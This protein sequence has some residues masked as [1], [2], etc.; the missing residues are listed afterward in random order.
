MKK[1]IKILGAATFLILLVTASYFYINENTKDKKELPFGVEKV[2]N[3]KL[4]IY[5]SLQFEDGV[6]ETENLN[7]YCEKSTPKSFFRAELLEL[8]AIDDKIIGILET[9]LGDH[10]SHELIGISEEDGIFTSLRLP[11]KPEQLIIEEES[12]LVKPQ[13]NHYKLVDD[14]FIQTVDEFVKLRSPKGGFKVEIPV[15]W[16]YE[17]V[18]DGYKIFHPKTPNYFAEIKF[19][20]RGSKIEIPSKSPYDYEFQ[21]IK[22]SFIKNTIYSLPDY[23]FFES[24]L[25]DYLEVNTATG[26]VIY[27]Q[28][29][30]KHQFNVLASGDPN[31]W[32]G[33]PGGLYKL[34]SKEG[35]R[36]STESEVYMP[37]SM[38]LYGK[39]LIHGEAYYPSG[40]PYTSAVSGGCVR[41]R[42]REMQNLYDLVETGLPVLSI[43]HETNSFKPTET[44]LRDDF[45]LKVEN[46]LIADIDSGRVFLDKKA[47]EEVDIFSLTKLMTAIVTSE[48]MGITDSLTARDYMLGEDDSNAEI[49]SGDKFRL[50]D[51]LAPLLVESSDN[52]AR[53]LSHYLGRD[54]T[55]Q[56]VREKADS[57]GMKDTNFNDSI[58]VEASQT[59]ARDLYYLVYYL[60]NTR[61]PLLD[62]SRGVWA[63]EINYQAFAEIKNQNVF[64]K[65][66]DFLGGQFEVNDEGLH[67]GVFL[68]NQRLGGEERKVAFIMLGAP[69]EKDL[70]SDINKIQEWLNKSFN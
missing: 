3:S 58:G 51:L 39:Y 24:D 38:R 44:N 36:F 61:K 18:E 59:T 52:A 45:E 68:F 64:F 10:K 49:T 23:H 19:S 65:N 4:D 48:Q 69:T 27:Y 11:D 63:P 55:L 50:V 57:V 8:K 14:K 32:N 66:K 47:E 28:D 67:N 12:F 43:T 15:N 7:D 53:V 70:V 22:D 20:S 41:V 2:K 37:F 35:L 26:N 5:C 16:N 33:T 30:E 56:Y 29:D 9:N 31:G 17:K 21:Q 54:N 25:D 60:I 34:L 1:I 46:V 6:F 42:N 13:N 40:V 62:I